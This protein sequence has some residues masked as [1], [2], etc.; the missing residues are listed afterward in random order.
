MKRAAILLLLIL[1]LIFLLSCKDEPE[2]DETEI[3][4][5]TDD[6]S[7]ATTWSGNSIYVIKKYDFYVDASL[8]IMPGAII[9]FTSGGANMT[10]GNNGMIVANGE[11]EDPVI[12]TAYADDA[13]GGDTNDDGNSTASAGS[14]GIIDVNGQRADFTWCEFHFGGNN[15]DGITLDYNTGSTGSL[16]HC[17]IKNNRGTDSGNYYYGAV[18]A[19]G[20]SAE[21]SITNTRFENNIVPLTINADISLDDSNTFSE[22]RYEGI[23]V[24][25]HVNGITSWGETEVAYVYTGSAL[26]VNDGNKLNLGNG[27]VLKFVKDSQMYLYNG[28]SNLSANYNN[29]A[30]VIYTSFKD[31]QIGGDSNGDGDATMPAP[32]DWFG[33]DKDNQK[34]WVEWENIRYD[35]HAAV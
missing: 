16:D 30:E 26:Q 27:V 4:E 31:D 22:N 32:N 34:E 35:S 14:W 17:L 28:T 29:P 20:A 11:E 1:P 21:L 18:N 6:I 24:S 23:Y 5:V 15:P 3:V 12:F 19:E 33:I 13:H 25:G 7:S 8:T 9:K 10:V 2:P